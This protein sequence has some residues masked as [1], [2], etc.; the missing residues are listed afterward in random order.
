MP[1]RP[2]LPSDMHPP[3]PPDPPTPHED[4]DG[5]PDPDRLAEESFPGSDPPGVGGPGV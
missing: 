4:E 3:E 5:D 2:E 1:T